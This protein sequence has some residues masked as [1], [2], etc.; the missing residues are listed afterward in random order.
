MVRS[1]N[2][3]WDI[4]GPKPTTNFAVEDL[5]FISTLLKLNKWC[6]DY[7]RKVKNPRLENTKFYVDVENIFV[8]FIMVPNRQNKPPTDFA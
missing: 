3:N 8:Q 1:C 7:D 2:S 4:F 6:F 5:F